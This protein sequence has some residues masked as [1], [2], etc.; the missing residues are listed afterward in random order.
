MATL[1]IFLIKYFILFIYW[2]CIWLPF[3]KGLQFGDCVFLL[4]RQCGESKHFKTLK[5]NE[6]VWPSACCKAQKHYFGN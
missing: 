6:K 3:F 5:Q 2:L 1:A 4:H